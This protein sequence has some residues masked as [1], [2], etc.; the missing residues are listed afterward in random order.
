M[1]KVCLTLLTGVLLSVGANAEEFN[2][3]QNMYAMQN[4]LVMLEQGFI[5]GDKDLIKKSTEALKENN[6][7]IFK[8]R[9]F[10]HSILPEGKK[11]MASAAITASSQIDKH[12]QTILDNMGN[13][14][15]YTAQE[16]FLG[17]QHA[18][19]QCHNIVRDW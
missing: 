6:H 11:H 10:V 14:K 13:I 15:P 1:K 19:M 12:I 16:A 7:N 9:E 5:T 2:L 3:K 4:N 18:C 8:D 17:I